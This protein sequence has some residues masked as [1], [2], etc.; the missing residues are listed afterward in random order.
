MNSA[1]NFLRR[2][3][4]TF[5]LLLF[6]FLLAT[7]LLCPLPPGNSPRAIV[8]NDK[9]MAQLIVSGMPTQLPRGALFL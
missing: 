2:D 8:L 5:C 3:A 9:I 6:S 7:L 1:K 4:K